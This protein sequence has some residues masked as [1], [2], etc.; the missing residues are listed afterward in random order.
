MAHKDHKKKEMG[1]GILAG[2]LVFKLAVVVC[3]ALLTSLSLVLVVLIIGPEKITKDSLLIQDAMATKYI[4]I[5]EFDQISS[6]YTSLLFTDDGQGVQQRKYRVEQLNHQLLTWI[7]YYAPILTE[8]PSEQKTLRD[9]FYQ[10]QAVSLEYFSLL[11]Q[12]N[13]EAAEKVLR[14]R[15]IR[16]LSSLNLIMQEMVLLQHD[17]NRKIQ[18][19]LLLRAHN[20]SDIILFAAS[21]SFALIFIVSI[22]LFISQRK[23]QNDLAYFKNKVG[24]I[25]K[26]KAEFLSNITHEIRTSM[27]SVIGASNLL[28]KSDLTEDQRNYS[29][30]IER[31]SQALMSLINDI[32]DLSKIEAQDTVFAAESIKLTSEVYDIIEQLYSRA[33]EKG[34]ALTCYISP[35]VPT[36]IIGDTYRLRQVLI[37]LIGNAIKYSD[38]GGVHLDIS[39]LDR[40]GDSFT[41]QFEVRDTGLGMTQEQI[42]KFFGQSDNLLTLENGGGVGVTIVK[43]IVRQKGGE[44]FVKSAPG[45]GTTIRLHQPFSIDFTDKNIGSVHRAT[46]F[47]DTQVLCVSGR[48]FIREAF[49]KIVGEYTR[50]IYN[51]R[52]LDHLRQSFSMHLNV[53]KSIFV[54]I[55]RQLVKGREGSFPQEIREAAKSEDLRIVLLTTPRDVSTHQTAFDLDYDNLLIEPIHNRSV[56]NC[57]MGKQISRQTVQFQDDL[58]LEEEER[59]SRMTG[60]YDVSTLPSVKKKTSIEDLLPTHDD[61]LS[62]EEGV[63][64]DDFIDLT[65]EITISAIGAILDESQRKLEQGQNDSSENEAPLE[66]NILGGLQDLL[67]KQLSDLSEGEKPKEAVEKISEA[68]TEIDPDAADLN[69]DMANLQANLTALSKDIESNTENETAKSAGNS[70]KTEDL[71]ADLSELQAGLEALSADL[72][73]ESQTSSEPS[74]TPS[75]D[76]LHADLFD[77][78][79]SL[80][81]ARET[82]E[83]SEDSVDEGD[84]KTAV[85]SSTELKETDPDYVTEE[86]AEEHRGHVLIVEDNRVNAKLVEVLLGQW[87]YKTTIAENGQ[88]AVDKCKQVR[89]DLILMD[90]RM[91]VKDGLSATREIKETVLLN[92]TTPIIAI[93]ADLSVDDQARCHDAGMIDYIQKPI[94]PE[95]IYA[96]VEAFCIPFDL[97]G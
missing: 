27:T 32:L 73:E 66:T 67:E 90:I 92:Q 44:I 3:L 59:I 63:D 53:G 76:D 18:S 56:E 30:M 20:V 15:F 5:S 12:Q 2:K 91:P 19:D 79:A 10:L 24:H 54:I 96:K 23:Q 26:V 6:Q 16:T 70:V 33:F 72:E 50:N 83:K 87:G 97:H 25:E 89:F 68:K 45:E 14:Q 71:E 8:T 11:E 74:K 94:N 77:Q 55:D 39:A 52:S 13:I 65:E 62:S 17:T 41:L 80:E 84:E 31:S 7:D 35:A 46:S 38:Q 21:I 47:R 57:L 82:Q 1:G 49:S 22:F 81:V 61:K 93:S 60:I 95:I 86:K 37:N 85:I 43:E 58:S 75:L 34:L 88:Q 40:D 64:P 51:Y 42:E 28:A 78:L 69:I 48:P 4:A 9:V 29:S 36:K